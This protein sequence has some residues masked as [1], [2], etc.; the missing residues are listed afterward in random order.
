MRGFVYGLVA[1]ALVPAFFCVALSIAARILPL[2]WVALLAFFAG[3]S[4]SYT[5]SLVYH[6]YP[7]KDRLWGNLTTITVS[8]WASSS[9]FTDGY[10][11]WM[12]WFWVMVVVTGWNAYHTDWEITHPEYARGVNSRVCL[13]IVYGIVCVVHVGSRV[14]FQSVFFLS[15]WGLYIVAFCVAMCICFEL[16]AA[17]WHGVWNGWY[18]DF[19]FVIVFADLLV[20]YHAIHGFIVSSDF[21]SE[22]CHMP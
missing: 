6:V 10:V 7:T 19:H 12:I 9:L 16:P 3:K 8:M 1:L 2:Q 5:L 17:V 20:A 11:E 14:G 13:L 21:G 15:M 18:E 4:L 22:E